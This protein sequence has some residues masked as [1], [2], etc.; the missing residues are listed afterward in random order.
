V[1]PQFTEHY[2]DSDDAADDSVDNGPTG[3]FTW[4]GFVPD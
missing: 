4:D 3:G 1:T 2:L